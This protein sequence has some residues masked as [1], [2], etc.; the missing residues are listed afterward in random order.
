M[1][2]HCIRAIRELLPSY[3]SSWLTDLDKFLVTVSRFEEIIANSQV[4]D[5]SLQQSIIS[6]ILSAVIISVAA[7]QAKHKNEMLSLWEMIKNSLLLKESPSNILLLD[8]DATPKAL[9]GGDFLPKA[10]T[11][12]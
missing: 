10:S 11:E 8:L 2:K 12:K 3:D 7:I 5:V 4:M 1:P 9:L 6:V